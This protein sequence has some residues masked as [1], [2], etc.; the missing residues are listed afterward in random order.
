MSER[1]ILETPSSPKRETTNNIQAF[2][3]VPPTV[4]ESIH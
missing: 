4:T 1:A 3:T 2:S